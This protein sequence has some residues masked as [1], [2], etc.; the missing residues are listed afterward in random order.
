MRGRGGPNREGKI[1]GPGVDSLM[2]FRPYLLSFSMLAGLAMPRQSETSLLS[3]CH[4]RAQPDTVRVLAAALQ[5]VSGLAFHRGLLLAHDDEFGRIYSINPATGAV[6][7]F[8]TLR[9]PI[10]D[11]FEVIAVLRDTVWL[12]TSTGNLYGVR[13]TPS[14]TPVAFSLR[15]TGLG[16]RCELEGLASDEAKGVLLL[17]CKTL[18]KKERGVVVYRWNVAL[19]A[20][21]TPATVT[22]TH[23]AVKQ[24]GIPN[25]HPSAIEI[26]PRTGHLL[27]LS[28]GPPALLEVDGA[29]IPTGG[30]RLSGRHPQPE[31]L[32]ITE[33][34]DVYISDEGGTG[35]GTLSVYRCHP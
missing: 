12:M 19:G 22:L 32:A 1:Y 10:R 3:Q 26:V 35:P 29:G 8:A 16:K 9:G 34:G 7:I 27:V 33:N 13:A 31:G 6:A 30:T 11:D 24:A 14:T 15:V 2:R 17:P 21:A 5:E 4:Y 25:L 18:P 23:G 28:S 20:L